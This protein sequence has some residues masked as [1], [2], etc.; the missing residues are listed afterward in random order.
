M[1]DVL[2][3]ILRRKA[4]EVTA[5]SSR[6]SLRE[7]SAQIDELPA[8][9]DFKP[10]L[11]NAINAARP[12]VIAEIKKASPS[13]GVIRE[14]FDVATI[15]AD[16]ERGGASALSVLTDEEFFQGQL[17]NLRVAR[18]HSSLPLL[19]KDFIVDQWQVYESRVA[20]ADCILLI[21]AALGDA[22]LQEFSLLALELGMDV[23]VEVHDGAELDRA[24]NLSSACILGVN[25]RDLR[26]FHTS[27]CTTLD[28]QERCPPDRLLVTESGV[29]TVD[30]VRMLRAN[31]IHCFLVGEALMRAER[32][33]AELQRLFEL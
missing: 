24:L 13:K 18:E 3:K 25:N 6:V 7:L 20:G 16:Y 1:S 28:L 21:V 22:A 9:R 29:A 11:V 8:T 2:R 14:D 23:L 26:T 30:N 19:R 5:R 17:G 31:G 33:G 27:L 15:A 4:E 10:S 32:P 12:A